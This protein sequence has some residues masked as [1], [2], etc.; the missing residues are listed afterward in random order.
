[1]KYFRWMIRFFVWSV[2]SLNGNRG[3]QGLPV[4]VFT[5]PNGGF[6]ICFFSRKNSK[7]VEVQD[8]NRNV[9]RLDFEEVLFG[10]LRELTAPVLIGN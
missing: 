3:F 10:R 1:M 2:R 5:M 8:A 9:F 6:I 4:Q 7:R